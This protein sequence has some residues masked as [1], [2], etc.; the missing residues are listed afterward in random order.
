MN[1]SDVCV[2]TLGFVGTPKGRPMGWV[3]PNLWIT[4]Y[5]VPIHRSTGEF[6]KKIGV[7]RNENV[8]FDG[9]TVIVFNIIT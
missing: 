8:M 4:S 2:L 1:Y 3:L 7:E 5:T 9:T 6:R